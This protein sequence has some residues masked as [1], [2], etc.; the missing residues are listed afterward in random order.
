MRDE[1]FFEATIE[2]CSISC[3]K[4]SLVTWIDTLC[5]YLWKFIEYSVS[6]GKIQNDLGWVGHCKKG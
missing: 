3:F 4:G 2:S 1:E 5:F 6:V